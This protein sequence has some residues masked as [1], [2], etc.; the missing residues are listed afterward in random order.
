MAGKKNNRNLAILRRRLQR[1]LA[2]SSHLKE[3]EKEEIV[4]YFIPCPNRIEID[5]AFL[6]GCGDAIPLVTGE[7]GSDDFRIRFRPKNNRDGG[8]EASVELLR[9]ARR[10][11]LSFFV[12]TFTL[13]EM[14]SK[15]PITHVIVSLM[16]QTFDEDA[17]PCR[18][19]PG[20]HRGIA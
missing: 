16:G 5:D 20:W 15:T 14:C 4:D 1:Q 6:A 11:S 3:E 8:N 12:C 7:P 17:H 18:E 13:I 19:A 10:E 9:D 2:A